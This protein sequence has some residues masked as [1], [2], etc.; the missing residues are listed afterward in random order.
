MTNAGLCLCY[1]GRCL[2][3]LTVLLTGSICHL[4]LD[5]TYKCLG[6]LEADGVKHDVMKT[7]LTTVYKQQV[8]KILHSHLNIKN[9]ILAIYSYALPLVR[10]SAGLI[11]W[12]QADMYKL[13]VQTRK[14]L[15]LHQA[16]NR[17]SDIDKLYVHRALGGRGLLSVS[18]AIQKECYSLE[19]VSRA[20]TSAGLHLIF[21]AQE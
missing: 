1:V 12:T 13:D 21:A 19:Q 7:Q 15:T 3:E 14:L 5:E 10:Y 8:C 11:K 20:I 6:V 17:N 2:Q 18:D 4:D 16:F 9:V